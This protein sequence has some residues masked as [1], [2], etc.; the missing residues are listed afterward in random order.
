M[1]GVKSLKRH[2]YNMNIYQ[3]VNSNV[4]RRKLFVLCVTAFTPYRG[5]L[6]MGLGGGVAVAP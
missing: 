2:S 1:F 3:N 5:S 6:V 4:L